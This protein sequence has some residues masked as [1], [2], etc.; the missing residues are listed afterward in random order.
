LLRLGTL[1]LAVY[2]MPLVFL[3]WVAAR[4]TAISRQLYRR[5]MRS[6]RLG[7]MWRSYSALAETENRKAFVR[8]I[9]TVM[10][11]G[12]QTVSA[13]DRLY[14]ASH[15]PTLI[16]WGEEDRIIPVSHAH[17][18]HEAIKGSRLRIL[19][20]VGHFPQTEAPERFVSELIEFLA[21]TP[22]VAHRGP[23]LR[24]ILQTGK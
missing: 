10:D 13:L 24:E 3:P 18:A 22:A 12:G 4:G 17:V 15:V 8:T 9:R 2:A 11:T 5:G 16:I 7:E 19:P 23:S 14:L 20:G 6:P 21:E 1:P